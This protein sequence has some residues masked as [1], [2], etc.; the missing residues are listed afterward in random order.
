MSV[1]SCYYDNNTNN[2]NNNNLVIDVM[3][4]THNQSSMEKAIRVMNEL[5][6]GCGVTRT[7]G[8]GISFAQLYAMSDNLTYNL[9]RNG[10][11]VYKYVPY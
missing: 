6:P 7:K 3:L 4:A 2:N 8:S 9:A 5:N 11:R 10:F 1:S